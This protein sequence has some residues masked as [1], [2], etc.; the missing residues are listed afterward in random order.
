MFGELYFLLEYRD[1]KRDWRSGPVE[2]LLAGHR[3]HA[4][5][6]PDGRRHAAEPVRGRQLERLR[7]AAGNPRRRLNVNAGSMR[8]NAAGAPRPKRGPAG[9]SC[10]DC[11][12]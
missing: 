12:D 5:A 9:E 6:Q 11:S 8:P 1:E 10:R 4:P 2:R 3:V 7:T